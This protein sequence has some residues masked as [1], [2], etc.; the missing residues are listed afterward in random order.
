M[1]WLSFNG[2]DAESDSENESD[3]DDSIL[4]KNCEMP[5]DQCESHGRHTTSR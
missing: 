2:T 3:N 5:V 1:S 4:D